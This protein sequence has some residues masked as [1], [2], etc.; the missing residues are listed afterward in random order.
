VIIRLIDPPMHEFLPAH[1]DLLRDATELRTRE[2]LGDQ[3]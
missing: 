1:D 3:L 2:R